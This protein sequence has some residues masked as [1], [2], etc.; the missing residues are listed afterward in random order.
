MIRIKKLYEESKEFFAVSD[1]SPFYPDGKGGQL[2]DRGSIGPAK[3]LY[4]KEVNGEIHHKLDRA[5]EPG[6]YSFEIDQVRRNDIAVQH[7]AQ[8]ILSA[9]F[10]KL[11][12]AQTL[13][14]HMGEETSTIDLNLPIL[15]ERAINDAEQ[16]A[17]QIVRS[18]TP[19]EI[20]YLDREQAEKLSLRKAISEKVGQTV[21]VVKVDDF[22]LSAC[23]GFHV[24]NTGQIGIVKI[25]D[26]EKTKGNLTRVYF[27]A[28]ERALQYFQKAVFV[29]KN[30]RKLLTCSM[31]DLSIR[32]ETLLEKIKTLS[33]QLEH[34]SEEHAEAIKDD[35]PRKKMKE[36]EVSFYEGFPSVAKALLKSPTTDLLVCRLEGEFALSS[37][38]VD[39]AQ[40][41]ERLKIMLNAPGGGGKKRGSIKT[42]ISMEKFLE[43]LEK[44]MEVM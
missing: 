19:V 33:S 8:H 44:I 13:S 23:G 29:F 20:L 39:C 2:G 7:T 31:E 40:I 42:N 36:L 17:N 15:T 27:V 37:E 6:E 18:C 21:R 43:I 25:I 30:L 35:L 16:L 3:V 34:L 10:L 1:E 38:K 26:W 14:F 28:G 4:V 32:I 22:D 41:V 12:Q 5:L 11:T 24:E 9:S